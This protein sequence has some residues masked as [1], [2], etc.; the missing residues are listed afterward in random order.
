MK[1]I[2]AAAAM[3]LA[4]ALPVGVLAQEAGWI[5]ISIE[6][7]K[8][9]GAVI[10]DVQ[11]NS[12]AA[13]AGLRTGDVIVAFNKESVAG[14]QQLIRLVR[15][16]PVGRTV[17]VKVRRD[18]RDET[19]QVTTEAMPGGLGGIRFP[20]AG[21]IRGG[22][23]RILRQIP[24]VRINT[25]YVQ[26]GI[27]VEEMTD[28]LRDYFGVYSNNGVLVTSVDQGSAAEKA[29]LKAGDVIVSIEGTN[30]RT[31]SDFSREMRR[32]ASRMALKIVRDKQERDLT[33]E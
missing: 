20:D 19:F 22:V 23:D 14:V 1:I 21:T 6:D 29:G 18:N 7:Q 24:R 28:Q 13:K 5:G 17:E 31:P 16:T 15:E 26:S 33:I 12:P 2:L 10:R 8:D 4:L 25:T 3:F 30:I 9:N 11:P 27:Q 32:S